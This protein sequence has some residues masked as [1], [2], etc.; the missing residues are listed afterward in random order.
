M[1]AS[2]PPIEWVTVISAMSAAEADTVTQLS[3]RSP[4]LV[5]SSDLMTLPFGRR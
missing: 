1:N 5:T 3:Q 4:L 2:L